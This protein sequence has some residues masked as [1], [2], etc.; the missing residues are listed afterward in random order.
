MRQ[1]LTE[2]T[3]GAYKVRVEALQGV[4]RMEGERRYTLWAV[5]RVGERDKRL[6]K[7]I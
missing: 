2:V 5:R 7:G 1:T 4:V 6:A 3:T